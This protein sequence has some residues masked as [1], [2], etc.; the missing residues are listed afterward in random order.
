MDIKL[1]I[2]V[3]VYNV[4]EYVEECI[5][6]LLKIPIENKEIIVINDGSTDRSIEIINNLKNKSIII[7]NEVNKGLSAARNT[8][9]K[10]A[11]G[12]YILF[13]DS[14]DYIISPQV[15]D[16]MV[17][18]AIKNRCDI[19]SGNGY[20]FFNESKK[21]P[22]HKN[23]ESVVNKRMNGKEYLKYFIKQN[24]FKPMVWL[25]I[26]KKSFIEDNKFIF[27]DGKY[28]EDIEWTIKV[29][30]KAKNVVSLDNIFY[31]YRQR[32]GSITRGRDFTK[33]SI[34]LIEI[35]FECMDLVKYESD[36]EL[37]TLVQ[38]EMMDTMFWAIM[39]ARK[40]NKN[41]FKEEILKNIPYDRC[42]NRK[43]KVKYGIFKVSKNLAY[44][45]NSIVL[46]V[47]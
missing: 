26:Y 5:K 28:H 10:Y 4:E 21:F 8:G 2:I 35:C 11:N 47:K 29:L 18:V 9:L 19:V 34:D 32:E 37:K 20:V 42:K 30:L 41:F 27:K 36:V 25:N 7:I 6:S 46:F 31:I 16:K 24:S 44:F 38:D 17:N 3:P 43:N 23:I 15:V 40:K 22:I 45:I 12:E 33:H 39:R 1:S 13:I 14:D